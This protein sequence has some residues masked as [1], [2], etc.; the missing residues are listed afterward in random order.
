MIWSESQQIS[1]LSLVALHSLNHLKKLDLE[2]NQLEDEVLGPLLKLQGL[3][4]LSLKGTRFTD[5]SLCTL[6]SLSNLINLSIGDTVL[7]NGGLNSFKPP[8]MLKLLDL[9]GCWL[10][11]QNAILLFH[12]KYPQIEVRHELVHISPVD[13]DASNQPSP[14]QKGQK[15]Q[16]SPKSQ[17]QSKEETVIGVESPFLLESSCRSSNFSYS[18]PIRFNFFIYSDVDQRWKYSRSELLALEH[19]TLTIDFPHMMHLG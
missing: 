14:S 15:Q 17:I 1:E 18:H 7:T 11:T 5:S 8:A 2:A 3:K 6:S 10:L 16:K 9:R 4:E 12:N 13:Q 19:S